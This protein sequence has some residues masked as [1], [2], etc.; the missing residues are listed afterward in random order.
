MTRTVATIYF[1]QC[2]LERTLYGGVF[3]APAVAKGDKPFLLEVRDHNQLERLPHIVGGGQFP[4]TILGQD[5]AVDI[6]KHWSEGALGM[7]PECR[8]GVWVVRDVVVIADETGTPLKDAFGSVQTRPA[9]PEEKETMWQEDLAE[10]TMAQARWAD[11]LVSRADTLFA[12]PNPAMRI[13]IDPTMRTA[14][15]YRGRER[16]WLDEARDL[17]AKNCQFCLKSLPIK[18]IKCMYCGEIVDRE[19]YSKMSQ[20]GSPVAKQPLPPPVQT[21]KQ[22]HAA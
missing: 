15:K 18:A 12:D 8:P 14:A 2:H 5:I 6:K 20:Q 4:R 7:T 9:T 17:D 16:E 21:G 1:R 13:L 10:N 19:G 11:Y 3:D 22:N